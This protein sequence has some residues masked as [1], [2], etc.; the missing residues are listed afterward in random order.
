MK[1]VVQIP[2][3]NEEESLPAALRAIPRQIE[4]ID[5]VQVLVIDDGS[6]DRTREVALENG[7]DHVLRFTRHKGLASGFMAGLDASLKLGAD[8]I[9]NTDAD[10]QYPA[11]D[12]PPPHRPHPPR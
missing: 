3:L 4:G 12:I 1:L 2:C 11:A 8:I 5:Q 9:V 10:N 7:A 6:K